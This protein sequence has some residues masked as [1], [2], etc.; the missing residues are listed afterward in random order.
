MLRELS[1]S[2]T[3]EISSCMSYVNRWL[4]RKLTLL[5]IADYSSY[6]CKN[7]TQRR[8]RGNG[9]IIPFEH[10]IEETN[11]AHISELNTCEKYIFF[12]F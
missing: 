12:S 5:F 9:C 4:L 6:L 2:K 1:N 7:S 11:I 3:A 10:V 8:R